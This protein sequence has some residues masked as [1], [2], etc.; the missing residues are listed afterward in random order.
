MRVSS[1]HPRVAP[2]STTPVSSSTCTTSG[3][4]SVDPVGVAAAV[5]PLPPTSDVFDIRRTLETVMTI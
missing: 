3:E 1:K 2:S 5:G 4:A